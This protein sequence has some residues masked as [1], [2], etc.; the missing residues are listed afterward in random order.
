V[1]NKPP[2]EMFFVNRIKPEY[3]ADADG[4][5]PNAAFWQAA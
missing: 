2:L 5:T 3:A 1:K 4:T